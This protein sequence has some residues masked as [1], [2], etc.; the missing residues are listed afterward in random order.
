MGNK[1]I[2]LI[3]AFILIVLGTWLALGNSKKS[4]NT[5]TIPG[6]AQS[7]AEESI[8]LS[9]TPGGVYV[10]KEIRVKL[11]DRVKIE[12]DPSA[13]VGGMDTVII[14]EYGI[15]KVI[16]PEDNIIEFVADK[17]GTFRIYCAN[18][19]GNGKLIVE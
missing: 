10:P 12:G 2:L 16:S 15:R 14:D 11:G 18:G 8:R 7:G 17:S 5:K 3:A 1:K 19:M 9:S 4:D 13:L 6:E